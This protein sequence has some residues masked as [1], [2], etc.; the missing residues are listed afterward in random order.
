MRT[1]VFL[2]SL[3]LSASW[4]QAQTDDPTAEF[5]RI[6]TSQLAALQN[7]DAE[8]AWAFA[9][10]S[11]RTMFGSPERFYQMVNQG[12][13]PL[14][15][16]TQVT[17][18]EAEQADPV[19]IQPVRLRDTNNDEFIAFY[20]MQRNVGGEWRIAGCQLYPYQPPSL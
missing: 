9:H 20:A 19:W 14:I 11:I 16:F 13:R 18:Q 8:G 1:L 5:R 4:V 3:L 2:V 15:D 6:I 12:Y 17:F 10:T 7:G